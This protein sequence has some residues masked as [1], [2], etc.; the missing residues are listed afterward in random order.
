[1]PQNPQHYGS[2]TLMDAS[3]E[4]SN[5]TFYF[6]AVTALNIAG[7][8]AQ[9]AD[10]RAAT[11]ALTLGN[12]VQDQWVGDSTRYGNT[13]PTNVNAQR[14]RKFLVSY[15]GTTTLSL[16]QLEIPTADLAGRMLPGTDM[17]DMSNAQVATWITA[18]ETL[19]RTP[20]GEAVNVVSIRHVGRNI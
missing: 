18:F 19:C 12:L 20:E 8:L 3:A 15:E 10:L 9:F 14:E 11:Q 7:F 5:F 6:G 13:P 16:Y 1:M 2:F 17:V 4:K